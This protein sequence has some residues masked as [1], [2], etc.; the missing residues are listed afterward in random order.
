MTRTTHRLKKCLQAAGSVL[1]TLSLVACSV[2]PVKIPNP[3]AGTSVEQAA[4]AV[5]RNPTVAP[6]VIAMEGILTVGITPTTAPYTYLDSSSNFSGLDVDYASALAEELGLKARFVQVAG[7]ADA[8]NQGV[9]VYLSTTAAGAPEMVVVGTYEESATALFR[10]GSTGVITAEELSGST[11]GVQAN[12]TSSGVLQKTIINATPREFD[13]VNEAFAA[14]DAGTVNYVLCDA[15]M[16][17]F[18]ARAY[19]TIGFC[20]TLG[21][22]IP[23][24][25]AVAAA[26]AE[27]QTQIQNAANQ[28][29]TNGR[30][31]LLRR[32]WLGDLPT[33]SEETRVAGL[34]VGSASTVVNTVATPDENA[35]TTGSNAVSITDVSTTSSS[36]SEEE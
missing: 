26:N 23:M 5:T 3:F 18:V 17:A 36:S 20:G 31:P 35:L 14:L 28:L 4:A 22:A 2:G 15:G 11:I 16:G 9:D 29:A 27:L 10:K 34:Q 13:S 21:E 30:T 32:S 6:P 24:G 8:V 19:D 12:S 33:L 25:V 1:V 7:S